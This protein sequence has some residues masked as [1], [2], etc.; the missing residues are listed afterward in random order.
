ME[1][2]APKCLQKEPEKRYESATAL[3]EDLRRFLGGE[4]IVARPVLIWDRGWRWCRRNPLVA[5]SLAGTAGIFL[6]AFVL[7]S[8]SYWRAEDALEKEAKQRQTADIARDE[9]QIAR[10]EAE[11]MQLAERWERY[12]SNIAAASAALQ[13]QNSTTVRS[14]LEAAPEE[15][16]N[17]EWQHIHSQL[18]EARH[19]WSVPG[20][21]VDGLVLSPSGRQIAVRCLAHNDVYL[22][23]V[24]AEKRGAVLRGHSAPVTSVAYRPDGKQVATGANDGTV[25]LWDPATG[26]ELALL[27]VEGPPLALSYSPDG[28]RIASLDAGGKSRLWDSTTGKEIV[29]LGESQSG[30]ESVVF[31]PDSK[32]VAVAAKEHVRVYDT[33]SGRPIAVLGPHEAPV[34]HLAYSPD[35]TRL[36][37]STYTGP[38]AIHLWD[39]ETSKQ[40]AMLRDNTA[41][42]LDMLF[43]PD[44]TRLLSR[45]V[46]PDWRRGSGTRPPAG[47]WPCWPDTRIKSIRLPSARTA[48]TWSRPRR[49]R[50][51]GSGTRS[52]GSWWPSCAGIPRS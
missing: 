12:R 18:D 8:W 43:S 28:S 23:D 44:S 19:V 33:G 14:A 9:A 11:R 42:V 5:G 2:I 4:P 50:R 24:S 39:R 15:H 6:T 30:Q 41:L 45:R 31:S 38:N 34:Y 7:V 16:R 1:T 35:G 52:R 48:S 25:R 40:V 49:T 37:S 17:W 46:Y 10:D 21:R 3:A 47:R 51:R 36:A 22:Y 29:V 27:R 13:L 32:L 20:G 26:R